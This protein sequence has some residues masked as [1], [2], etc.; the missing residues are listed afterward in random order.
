[1]IISSSTFF[2]SID[3]FILSQ[4]GFPLSMFH[5]SNYERSTIYFNCSSWRK[6]ASCLF[7]VSRGP[8]IR[9]FYL[10]SSRTRGGMLRFFLSYKIY[11]VN[12]AFSAT[13]CSSSEIF[14][15]S[16]SISFF[17]AFLDSG[18]FFYSLFSS[19]ASL[20]SYCFFSLISF[21]SIFT[22]SMSF[23]F[24]AI[25]LLTFLLFR[26]IFTFCVTSGQK[27]S[28]GFLKLRIAVDSPKSTTYWFSSK[29]FES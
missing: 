23:S 7:E 13:N 4:I 17:L 20:R 11:S 6:F 18:F 10:F 3:S 5:I 27:G 16:R 26:K 15:F 29:N 14:Y 25:S 28:L 24:E 2:Y 12:A 1:M 8:I 9:I 19:L 22:V 21:N